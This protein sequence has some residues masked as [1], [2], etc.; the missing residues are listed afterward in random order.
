MNFL[1]YYLIQFMLYSEY[2]LLNQS[3]AEKLEVKFLYF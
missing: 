3:K 2:M 1:S